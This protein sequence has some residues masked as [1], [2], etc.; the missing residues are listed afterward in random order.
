[1]AKIGKC[2]NRVGC[3]LAYTG[4]EIRFE[5]TPIC[6]ECGEPLTEIQGRKKGSKIGI[7]ILIPVV[8]LVIAGFGFYAAQRFVTRSE[9]SEK[10]NANPQATDTQAD[11]GQKMV[12][13]E[14][15]VPADVLNEAKQLTSTHLSDST[16]TSANTAAESPSPESKQTP[17]NKNAGNPPENRA[18]PN[19]GGNLPTDSEESVPNTGQK[20]P[21][22]QKNPLGETS[23]TPAAQETIDTK[24]K[25]LSSSQLNAT[26]E[27]VL[28]R[29]GALP[30]MSESEKS[31]L[32]AKV[33]TARYM[34][35][36]S[37]V[38]FTKGSNSLSRSSVEK[39][40]ALFKEPDLEEKMSDPTLVFIVAGYADTGGDA[41]L[42]LKLSDERAEAVTN[43]LVQD[44]GVVNLVR[45]V[46]MGGTDLLS[47]KRADQNR[48]VEVWAV[49]P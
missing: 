11:N 25:E 1:M 44:A 37:V 46:G 49:I 29:I 48:A 3:T 36:I 4:H 23:G 15:R 5:G 41:K 24:P 20:G 2:S 32:L 21:N 39:L 9:N 16:T 38:Y 7:L 34:Q 26:K 22:S 33:E 45:T 6:P 27:D 19:A 17:G 13:G 28:K 47:G 30:K 18:S 14:S 31:K 35:R 42:N 10:T 43:V 40:A 12:E 8:F